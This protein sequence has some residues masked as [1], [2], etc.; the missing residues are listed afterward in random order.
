MSHLEAYLA[1][2]VYNI[3]FIQ[4]ELVLVCGFVSVRHLTV[5]FSCGN[6]NIGFYYRLK[7]QIK[8]T[9]TLLYSTCHH[10]CLFTKRQKILNSIYI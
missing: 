5:L 8:I 3:A 9:N 6:Q 4:G 7:T 10:I 1:Q 2:H